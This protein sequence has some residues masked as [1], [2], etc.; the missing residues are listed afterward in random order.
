M[1]P[2]LKRKRSKPMSKTKKIP[3][4]KPATVAPVVAKPPVASPIVATTPA[5]PA[6]KLP[7]AAAVRE[8]RR[9]TP[10]AKVTEWRVVRSLRAAQPGYFLQG[11]HFQKTSRG[12]SFIVGEEVHFKDIKAANEGRAAKT[13]SPKKDEPKAPPAKANGSIV[14]IK[15]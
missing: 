15:G 7:P 8:N 10:G 13:G 3:V 4:S 6:V 11:G 2:K 12:N 14:P 9:I 5:P 1:K